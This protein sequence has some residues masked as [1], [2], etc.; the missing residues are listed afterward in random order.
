[1]VSL[2]A[3]SYKSQAG[4]FQWS[5]AVYYPSLGMQAGLS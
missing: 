1:M 2:A 5:Y 4:L 3:A